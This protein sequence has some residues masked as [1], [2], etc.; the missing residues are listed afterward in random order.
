MINN[1]MNV[2]FIQTQLKFESGSRDRQDKDYSWPAVR[3]SEGGH[4]ERERDVFVLALMLLT[5]MPII[6][7]W[8]E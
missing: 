5:F 8:L 7:L 1:R 4:T 2:K 3:V 6:H